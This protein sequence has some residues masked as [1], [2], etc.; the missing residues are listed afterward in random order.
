MGGKRYYL[1]HK[2]HPPLKHKNLND[3]SPYY[4]R[5]PLPLSTEGNFKSNDKIVQCSGSKP[6]Q[7]VTNYKTGQNWDKLLQIMT[8]D[9]TGT[10]CDKFYK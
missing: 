3:I 10:N 9:K 5:A 8:W 4:T 7:F 6:G 1:K 2:L